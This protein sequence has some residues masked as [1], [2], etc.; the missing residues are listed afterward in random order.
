M[1][2]GITQEIID[3][4]NAVDQHEA[5]DRDYA[6][7]WHAAICSVRVRLGLIDVTQP[8]VVVSSMGEPCSWETA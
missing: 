6:E 8:P 1:S 3:A 7:G 5:M 4:L 2:D